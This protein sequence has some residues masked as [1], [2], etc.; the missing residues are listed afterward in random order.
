MTFN[1]R[2]H[3]TDNTLLNKKAWPAHANQKGC[4]GPFRLA[5]A[6]ANT[7]HRS[8]VRT[9]CPTTTASHSH[10]SL[11]RLLALRSEC[12]ADLLTWVASHATRLAAYANISRDALRIIRGHRDRKQ[13]FHVI[14]RIGMRQH[15]WIVCVGL[16]LLASVSPTP[17]PTPMPMFAMLL[18]VLL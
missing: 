8:T 14:R 13:R 1:N 16:R 5:T 10:T 17:T 2:K 3:K 15:I 11:P 18:A 4:S 12:F 6:T 9:M 7:K